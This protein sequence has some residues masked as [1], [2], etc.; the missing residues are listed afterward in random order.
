MFLVAMLSMLMVGCHEEEQHIV[1]ND[2]DVE[3]LWKK[4]GTQEYWRY[5]S[6][7]SGVT[8]DASDDVSE[9]ESNLVFTWSLSGDV[10]RHV[11]TGAQGNQAVPK[12]YT[13]TE[14]SSS[15]MKWKDDYGS[16][17]TL[18]RVESVKW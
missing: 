8:W 3:G 15:K 9:E 12:I 16:S 18:E 10:L 17:Y 11:F 6:D 5:R 2:S 4:S 1:V 14:I 13:I 7:Y